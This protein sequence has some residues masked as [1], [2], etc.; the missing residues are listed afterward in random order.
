MLYCNVKRCR[1]LINSIFNA[2]KAP[3][4]STWEDEGTDQIT[5]VST[6]RI[7]LGNESAGA[8]RVHLLNLLATPVTLCKGWQSGSK[9]TPSPY[10]KAQTS[11]EAER[12]QHTVYSSHWHA[13]A[14][15]KRDLPCFAV[16]VSTK[17][18]CYRRRKPPSASR[19][20][21]CL[22]IMMHP[23]FMKNQ[24]NNPIGRCVISYLTN[25][26]EQSSKTLGNASTQITAHTPANGQ[27]PYW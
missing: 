3:W 11:E 26:H 25:R 2:W 6:E 14:E 1:A 21:Y 23:L 7:F 27:R 15:S 8:Y 4:I 13:I 18:P 12:L 10:E 19:Y 9:L 17:A 22:L 20:F 5:S 16:Q 24:L